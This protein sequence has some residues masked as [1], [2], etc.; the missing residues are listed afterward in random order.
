M[1]GV[2]SGIS[3]GSTSGG[4]HGRS[5]LARYWAI[6]ELSEKPNKAGNPYKDIV[7]L[8]AIDTPATTTS[9]AVGDAE[10]L[11][12]LRAIRALLSAI[13]GRL[14]TVE[15]PAPEPQRSE[16]DEA[17]PRYLNGQ[18]VGDNP[19]EL[20]AFQEHV[21]ATG[22][23][24]ASKDARRGGERARQLSAGAPPLREPPCP[25]PG[26]RSGFQTRPSTTARTAWPE[27]RPGSAND[28]P[29]HAFLPTPDP[30]P[31]PALTPDCRPNQGCDRDSSSLG[32]VHQNRV[33]LRQMPLEAASDCPA[34][35]DCE[36]IRR[37]ILGSSLP[38][39]V[40][41]S[42]PPISQDLA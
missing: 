1:V 42:P 31:R 21:A 8:E 9:A 20:Q 41:E 26:C 2:P 19:A 3:R 12:E 30:G 5:N 17:F 25:S 27:N 14:G 10:I 13:A 7:A 40:T 33:C 4:S 11:A 34:T 37:S 29:H 35:H 6:Y 22:S 36:L 24:P 16:L 18:A 32:K 38:E 23:A 15:Q 39:M 28:L